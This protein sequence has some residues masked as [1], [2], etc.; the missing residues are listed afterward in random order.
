MKTLPWISQGTLTSASKTLILIDKTG[1]IY[2]LTDQDWTV[3]AMSDF[4]I[5]QMQSNK[6]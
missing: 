6:S 1:N 3:T 5:L 2:F 4:C